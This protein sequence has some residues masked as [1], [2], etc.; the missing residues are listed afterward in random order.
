MPQLVLDAKHLRISR[1]AHS[2]PAFL[3]LVAVGRRACLGLQTSEHSPHRL[4]V[5]ADL[6]CAG[7]SEMRRR[8]CTVSATAVTLLPG[9]LRSTT[10]C[11]RRRR[12]CCGQTG[13][14]WLKSILQNWQLGV[15][16]PDKWVYLRPAVVYCPTTPTVVV[17]WRMARSAKDDETFSTQ[18]PR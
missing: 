8:L 16:S 7:S 6:P 5:T 17:R 18:Q 4:C 15:L 14:R 1:A 12:S 10:V 3:P 9:R 13:W 2:Q 11:C